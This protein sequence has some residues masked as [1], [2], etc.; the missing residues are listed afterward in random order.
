MDVVYVY[1]ILKKEIDMTSGEEIELKNM[2][3]SYTHLKC[4]TTIESQQRTHQ[5]WQY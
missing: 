3:V 2:T 1:I 4:G 5:L